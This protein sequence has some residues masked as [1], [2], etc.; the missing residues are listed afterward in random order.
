MRALLRRFIDWIRGR[1]AYRPINVRF[2]LPDPER[3]RRALNLQGE[4][5]RRGRENLPPL[6]A[7]DLDDVEQR[8]VSR[9]ETYKTKSFDTYS[10]NR[11]SYASSL[12]SLVSRPLEAQVLTTPKNAQAEF[13]REVSE[14]R[15]ELHSIE[16][17][18]IEVSRELDDFKRREKISRAADYPESKSLRIGLVFV[19]AFSE[20]LANT[21][22]F[23]EG[24]DFGLV[25]GFVLALLAASSNA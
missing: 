10:E 8:I 12:R 22:F 21:F 18:A 6:E 13:E 2:E 14:G 3:I 20:A 23:A 4:G 11:E 7:N 16:Q 9:I 19:L 15:D 25:G 17:L 24:S 5:E 1:R